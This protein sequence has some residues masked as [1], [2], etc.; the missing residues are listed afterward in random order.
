MFET[1]VEKMKPLVLCS[2]TFFPKIGPFMWKNMIDP[3]QD[4]DNNLIG[5]IH[6]ACWV[7]KTTDR[8]NM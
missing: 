7:P 4:T 2:I 1:V 3:R 5:R 8:H 6:Y